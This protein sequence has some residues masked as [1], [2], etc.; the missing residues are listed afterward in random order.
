[1]NNWSFLEFLLYFE[2]AVFEI[3]KDTCTATVN[4]LRKRTRIII[5][6]ICVQI[7]GLF[8][9]CIVSGDD[10]HSQSMAIASL[11]PGMTNA[12]VEITKMK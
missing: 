2:K 6:S 4:I 8:K 1:V 11:W 7:M 3:I 5:N 10:T 12:D 9:N